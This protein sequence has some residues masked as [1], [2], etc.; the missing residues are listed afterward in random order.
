MLMLTRKP[1][2]RL[3]GI[4]CLRSLSLLIGCLLCYTIPDPTWGA[5]PSCQTSIASSFA[6]KGQ[7]CALEGS[8]ADDPGVLALPGTLVRSGNPVDMQSG[9]KALRR[10]HLHGDP[11]A[12]DLFGQGIALTWT[13][14]YDSGS[15]ALGKK[16]LAFDTSS[17][18]GQTS[19]SHAALNPQASADRSANEI[20]MARPSAG[21]FGH[22]WRH[23]YELRL[24]VEKTRADGEAS[25][26]DL[27]VRIHQADATVHRFRYRPERAVFAAEQAELGEIQSFD[28]GPKRRWLWRQPGGR[29]AH[30]DAT[31]RLRRWQAPLGQNLDL[32]YSE[33]GRLLAIEQNQNDLRGE[34]R[35]LAGIQLRWNARQ[36]LITEAVLEHYAGTGKAR[37]LARCSYRYRQ[38]GGYRQDPAEA[39][40]L[41][42]VSCQHSRHPGHDWSEGYFYEDAGFAQGLTRVQSIRAKAPVQEASYAYD[43]WGRVTWSQGLGQSREEA[44]RI[45]Y[46]DPASKLPAWRRLSRGGQSVEFRFEVEPKASLAEG[47]TLSAG[48]WRRH[49]EMPCLWCPDLQARQESL[50]D[51]LGRIVELRDRTSGR[52]IERRYYRGQDPTELPSEIVRP[53]LRSGAL[54]RTRIERNAQGLVSAITHQGFSPTL[55]AAGFESIHRAIRFRYHPDGGGLAAVML[56]DGSGEAIDP[57]QMAIAWVIPGKQLPEQS[58]RGSRRL[59]DDFGRV[60]LLRNPQGQWSSAGY[61]GRDRLIEQQAADGKRMA[62]RWD[63]QGNPLEKDYGDGGRA[64]FDWQVSPDKSAALKSAQRKAPGQDN[65]EVSVDWAYD[66]AGRVIGRSHRIGTHRFDWRIER[67]LQG[68]VIAERLPDGGSLIYR[69]DLHGL[70]SLSYR[71]GFAA[72][73]QLLYQRLDEAPL[74]YRLGRFTVRWQARKEDPASL[75]SLDVEGLAAWALHPAAGKSNAASPRLAPSVKPSS[76]VGETPQAPEAAKAWRYDAAQ[77]WLGDQQSSLHYDPLG[78]PAKLELR[79]GAAQ[80][81]VMDGWRQL[82]LADQQARVQGL[83]VWVGALPVAWIQSGRVY[84]LAID[85]RG[86]P[87][88]AFSPDGTL[89]WRANYFHP[90][91]PSIEHLTTRQKRSVRSL[92]DRNVSKPLKINLGVPGRFFASDSLVAKDP[93][94]KNLLFGANRVLDAHSM[95]FLQAD[96]LGPAGDRDPYGYAEGEPWRYVDPWGLAKLTYFAILQAER[97]KASPSTQGFTIGR[98][99][100][101]LEAIAPTR[102]ASGGLG[103]DMGAL[104]QEYASSQQAL[105]F[106]SQGSF[107]RSQQDPLL[108]SWF[109]EDSLR[110][111]ANQSDEIMAGFRQHYGA[112]LVTQSAFVVEDFDDG[113]ATRLMA[114]LSRDQQARRACLQPSSVWLPPIRFDDGSAEIRPD[115]IQSQGASVQRLL[116]CE[117]IPQGIP[118]PIYRA[119]FANPQEQARVERLQAAAQLQEAPSPSS[120][121][122]DCSKDACRTRTAIA[123]NGREYFASYGSTQFVLETFL[124]TLRQDLMLAKDLDPR[125]LS[126]LGLDQTRNDAK[127]EPRNMM[128]WINQGISRAQ[129][130]AQAFDALRSRYGKGLTQASALAHWDKMSADQQRQWQESSGLDREAF[131]DILGFLPDSRARTE[132]EAR[133]AFAAHAVFRLGQSHDAKSSQGF[134]AWLKALFSDPARFGLISRLMLR[135]NLRDILAA[136]ALQSRLQN[137]EASASLQHRQRQQAIEQDIAYRVA[138]MHNGGKNVPGALDPSRAAPAH[139]QSYAQEFMRVAGR[140]NWESL[141]CG[142]SLGVAGLQMQTLRLG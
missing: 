91:L 52:W 19:N 23:G 61:D 105:L 9:R 123:V 67:D 107:R 141:R 139:L 3:G 32:H 20:T 79:S 99:S 137:L 25:S 88:L 48:R 93:R 43:A 12:L 86:A 15:P 119:L 96:P 142:Q 134:G 108:G 72:F 76:Q 64:V 122:P 69:Y 129:A 1:L 60:V 6:D 75:Q 39:G 26:K 8:A 17:S 116:E 125:T 113:Q 140:G 90:L 124:R 74:A 85:W 21:D 101:L 138:L 87:V 94:L 81:M 71:E 36:T 133:N 10:L 41:V 104:Q 2:R 97:G 34:T 111:Q 42:G 53:S 98:W 132:T 16:P 56:D 44:L 40:L 5:A 65:P 110:F 4:D 24:S 66:Q 13:L 28:A 54:A 47:Q 100:F 57:K 59:S 7:G 58:W 63:L 136:P 128:W 35:K 45:E 130:A 82:L 115:S 78:Q 62:L 126:W 73:S 127:G 14:Y 95:R 38:D 109:G 11:Q 70:H 18:R 84:H 55:E 135:N 118:E 103:S 121:S 31:G 89:R 77:A 27:V 50:R 29:L 80:M 102:K 112:S 117:A 22:A 106:D 33:T 120:I 114:L 68:R 49:D 30:F 51:A 37:E 131:I 46:S 92:I 83:V